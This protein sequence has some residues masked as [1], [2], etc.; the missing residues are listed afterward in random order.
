MALHERHVLVQAVAGMLLIHDTRSSGPRWRSTSSAGSS[1]SHR[2]RDQADHRIDRHR[3]HVV[4]GGDGRAALQRDAGDRAT[5]DVDAR[6]LGGAVQ[7]DALAREVR[8]PRI[9]P[10]LGRRAAHR[11]VR[12]VIALAH[13]VEDQLHRDRADGARRSVLRIHRDHRARHRAQLLL[14]VCRVGV[15]LEKIPPRLALVLAEKWR[16]SDDVRNS[17]IFAGRI[18]CSRRRRSADLRR[19][20]RARRGCRTAW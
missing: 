16:S 1:A 17:R 7:V 10:H 9:D 2:R 12:L 4:V 11:A 15:A 5:A 19:T 20:A 14:E 13:V 3:Q 18:T 8:R 6:D